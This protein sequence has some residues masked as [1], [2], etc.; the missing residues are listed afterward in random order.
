MAGPAVFVGRDNELSQLLAALGG[1]SRLVLV[2]GDAGVGKASS[3][4]AAVTGR[5]GL[6]PGL[7]RIMRLIPP[8]QISEPDL[9]RLFTADRFD[10]LSTGTTHIHT[11]NTL[12]DGEMIT[13]PAIYAVIRPRHG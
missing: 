10:V 13:V 9:V 8:G 7:A 11:V 5:H 1:E 3:Y 6:S 4:F 2:A 12:P